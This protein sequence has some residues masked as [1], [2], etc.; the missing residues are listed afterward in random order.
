MRRIIPAVA[1]V[2]ALAAAS[3]AAPSAAAAA[4]P[5]MA[6]QVRDLLASQ[7]QQGT[8]PTQEPPA[9]LAVEVRGPDQPA[10]AGGSVRLR[11]QIA[12]EAGAGMT[13]AFQRSDEASGNWLTVGTATSDAHGQA[14]AEV[15]AGQGS[16]GNFRAVAPAPGEGVVADATIPTGSA[17]SPPLQIAMTSAASPAITSV[18][19]TGWPVGPGMASNAQASVSVHVTAAGGASAADV[20]VAI[21]YSS[22]GT[23]WMGVGLP[24]RADGTGPVAPSVT[25][26]SGNATVAVVAPSAPG[27]GITFRAVAGLNSFPSQPSGAYNV[28]IDSDSVY[29]APAY[30]TSGGSQPNTM[31]AQP[32]QLIKAQKLDPAGANLV[33][34]P[35]QYPAEPIN[36]PLDPT[37]PIV[38][39]Q[40]AGSGPPPCLFRSNSADPCVVGAT[41]GAGNPNP[42]GP[43]DQF[44]IMYSD[45]RFM[46][47]PPPY[48]DEQSLGADSAT[49]EAATALVLVPK[50]ATADSKVVAWSH[51]TVGQANQCS[52][53]RGFGLIE[54]A[55]TPAPTWSM[56]GAQLNVGDMSFFLEQTLA[57]GNI[58]VMP[59]Y[60]GIGVNGPTGQKKS[61]LIGQQEARDMHYAVKSL[62]TTTAPGWQGINGN[63][64]TGRDF[65][66]SGHSQGGHASMWT[67]IESRKPWAQAVGLD[68]KGVI[69]A[70]PAS[71]INKILSLQWEGLTGWAL[72]PP[73]I[74]TYALQSPAMANFARTNNVLTEAGIEQFNNFIPL[75]TTQAGAAAVPLV[76]QGLNFLKDPTSAQSEYAA[77]E[78]VF[79]QQS[80]A[81]M[82]GL[83]NS[84]PTDL[85]FLLVSGTADNVVVAQIN[86]A[87]QQSFCGVRNGQPTR[88]M[89][90]FWDPVLP[91][92][93]TP[94]KSR[95]A[96]GIDGTTLTV[97]QLTGGPGAPYTKVAG[98]NVGTTVPINNTGGT[99]IGDSLTKVGDTVIDPA[100]TIVA[101]NYDPSAPT[102]T[103]SS[104]VAVPA[105]AVLT[106]A[107]SAPGPLAVGT[108]V[109]WLPKTPSALPASA[110]ISA[111]GTGTGGV[112]TYLLSSAPTAAAPAGTAFQVQATSPSGLQAPDHTAVLTSPFTQT[113]DT[114][115][116]SIVEYKG[117]ANPATQQP[118]VVAKLGGPIPA[119]VVPGAQLQVS[120]LPDDPDVAV[121]GLFAVDAVDTVANTITYGIFGDGNLP[122][123]FTPVDPA[124]SVDI[125]I[126]GNVG[127]EILDFTSKTFA[128]VTPEANCNL[129]D[130]QRPTGLTPN[131]TAQT[132]YDFANFNV[133]DLLAYQ[134]GVASHP[135]FYAAWGSP[136]LPAP[137]A[138]NAQPSLGLMFLDLASFAGE[139]TG[140]AVTWNPIIAGLL[141]SSF[142]PANDACQRP[143]LWPFGADSA[144]YETQNVG[145]GSWGMYPNDGHDQKIAA[146]SAP[147]PIPP[148]VF[149][150]INPTRVLDTRTTT[151]PVW[152]SAPLLVDVTDGGRV[153]IPAEA[154]AVAYNITVTGQ[155]SPGYATVT[156]GDV[157]TRPNSST[158]NWQQANQTRAN[159]YI[160]GMD[161]SHHIKVFVGGTSGYSQ[162]IIDILGYY[163]PSAG[164]SVFVP[165]SP[166][167]AYSSVAAGSPISSGQQ[168]TI[169]VLNGAPGWVPDKATGI[170]YNLTVTDTVGSGFLAVAPASV[171][172]I[173]D[174]STIN[175]FASN[176][177]IANATQT[178]ITDGKVNVF[179]GGGGSTNFLIDVVGYFVQPADVPP[180]VIGA[181]FVPIDPVRA[182]DSRDPGA[183]GALA[184]G[185]AGVGPART[186]SVA[187][188][189][190]VPEGATSVA[191]NLTIVTGAS[192][193]G[194]LTLAPGGSTLPP[195]SNINWFA[196]GTVLANGS[197][198][199]VDASRN[200]TS[201]VGGGPGASSQYVVDIAG[202]Y[203]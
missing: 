48:A 19:V 151:G 99:R 37:S 75:C 100:P 185:P 202:Y 150:E 193:A 119:G 127:S 82:S 30:S 172:T 84:F 67:G 24:M 140:C 60:M 180:G 15:P 40:V 68:L 16:V 166:V 39:P 169:D 161:P 42:A 132:W 142:S 196:P 121:N 190:R 66:V 69:A 86:A 55:G 195:S 3:L 78:Q 124:A 139:Q 7:T 156:P 133:A 136:G 109:N 173:P 74:Q 64:W 11:S 10:A 141:D 106:F 178:G 83:Q 97:T 200:V 123:D 164:G 110:T 198:V 101:I 148:A 143:G 175:W 41:D 65:V 134:F 137:T 186:T 96:G 45:K 113:V 192:S 168:R 47:N 165:V 88:P 18:T 59:D 25:D 177:T 4:S 53:T 44:R 98:A 87:M 62:Q 81:S 26:A 163:S 160:V 201:W 128:G 147:E 135:K 34:R 46:V 154:T 57:D 181:R 31:P 174:V 197:I 120:G 189:N 8:S 76:E 108:V 72:G 14:A 33:D 146:G 54:I 91:G 203:R 145:T 93:L 79:A 130:D 170:A 17:A 112:G 149:T 2:A 182:Y 157:A 28:T 152:A 63:P 22:N 94:A 32:G 103:L 89:R 61:Y 125:G 114:Q 138:A 50:N 27:A 70:A 35:L 167:R 92:V 122:A 183:G 43:A 129:A 159:G 126:P 13:V 105:G 9:P 36:N 184:G 179:A 171:A 5:S 49:L 162:V 77:W 194:F 85:P 12:G 104:E 29:N 51:P 23:T 95:F 6:D 107:S 80:P 153:T 111:L 155:D 71:D 73:I 21:Q 187:V 116:G 58:V 199:G 90:A 117:M 191:Y 176:N 102:V 131:V 144:V 56:G 188:G 1:T 115:V 118:S 38:I 20:G 52:V 158:I